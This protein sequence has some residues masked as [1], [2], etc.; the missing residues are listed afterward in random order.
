M[1]YASSDVFEAT[2]F[3]P[4]A[5]WV[6]MGVWS[7]PTCTS[8]H[9][10]PSFSDSPHVLTT[11]TYFFC[12]PK[13]ATWLSRLGMGQGLIHPSGCS[14]VTFAGTTFQFLA[15]FLHH[16]CLLLAGGKLWCICV[17]L[18][19]QQ[20]PRVPKEAAKVAVEKRRRGRERGR[21]REQF[22]HRSLHQPS[23]SASWIKALLVHA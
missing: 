18:F 14:D 7:R 13:L 5:L 21:G 4:S 19:S 1:D 16:L 23:L 12:I 3:L 17:H 6:S 11:Q 10:P 20:V 8:Q 2:A 22:T 9:P 15:W